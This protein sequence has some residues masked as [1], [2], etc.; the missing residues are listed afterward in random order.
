MTTRSKL[1]VS[2]LPVYAAW[3][4]AYCNSPT[5]VR[6]LTHLEDRHLYIVLYVTRHQGIN[7]TTLQKTAMKR[8]NL[9]RVTVSTQTLHYQ[10]NV[11][12]YQL[13][14]FYHRMS[15]QMPSKILNR[16]RMMAEK[17]NQL[18]MVKGYILSVAGKLY[19][20]RHMRKIFRNGVVKYTGAYLSSVVYRRYLPYKTPTGIVGVKVV[21]MSSQKYIP[22][23][24]VLS[25]TYEQVLHDVQ[26]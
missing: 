8:F 4:K 19:G 22:G 3:V 14:A 6:V 26:K 18:P 13:S 25:N 21:I 10:S 17:L 2:R 24:F 11:L 20:A 23:R 7:Y 12:A 15:G 5:L 16:V 1:Q 9:A